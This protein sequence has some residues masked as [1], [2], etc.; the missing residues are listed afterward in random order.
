VIKKLPEDVIKKI[1]AGEVIENPASCVREIIENSLDAG[2]RHIKISIWGGGID[3]I[4]VEDDG[5]GMSPE[6][7]PIAVQRFTTSK[8]SSFED[9]K[10]LKTLGFRGEALYA[11]AQVSDLTITSCTSD[12][13]TLGWECNFNAGELISSKPAPRKKGTTVIVKDLFFNLPVR[14]KFLLSKR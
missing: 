11:I 4:E 12:D 9:L 14:R 3:A 13:A 6:E 10:R 2:A 1:S 7:I 5:V 8:I